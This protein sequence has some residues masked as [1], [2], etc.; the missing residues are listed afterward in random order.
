MKKTISILLCAVLLFCAFPLITSAAKKEAVMVSKDVCAVIAVSANNDAQE[1]YAA[2][3]LKTKI[4]KITGKSP[5]ITADPASVTAPAFILRKDLSLPEENYTVSE[6]DG[7]VTIIGGGQRGVLYGV[8]AFLENCCDCRY[9]SVELEYTPESENITVPAGYFCDYSPYFE[10]R[11]TDW[12]V[13][14]N[15][16]YC[17]EN[18]LN[19][20]VYAPLCTEGGG[21]IYYISSFCHTLSSEFCSPASY[22]ETHPEYYA[23]YNGE[24]TPDQLC[25]TNPDVL[26]IVTDEVLD[27]CARKHDPSQA[28]QIVSLTQSDNQHYC[29]CEKCRAL[30]DSAGSH[31]GTML[32]FVNAVAKAVKAAG[33]D[34]VAID[35]FAYQ[36]TRTPPKNIVP[37][38]NVIVRLCSI[39]CCFGHTLDD[40][41]CE[42]NTAFM[43][44]LS[45]WSRICNR[46][47]VWD[48]TTNY[49]ETYDIFPN[50]GVMQR[51]MQIFCENNVRGI[52]EEGAYYVTSCN[53]EFADLRSYLLCRLMRDPYMDYD[54][55][56]NGFLKA[57]YGPGWEYIREFLDITT[58]NAADYN[59]HLGIYQSAAD[60]LPTIT[61]KEIK[62]CDELWEKA[63]AAA[64]DEL[65]LNNLKRSELCWRYWKCSAKKG[66]FGIMQPFFKKMTLRVELKN[67]ML[68]FGGTCLG[69]GTRDRNF[70]ELDSMNLLRIPIKWST[71]YEDVIWQTIDPFVTRVY[72][73]YKNVCSLFT[74]VC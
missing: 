27:L 71:R 53:G 14:E 65:Y 32:T 64:D 66:E 52:Y 3:V 10:Y 57:Y 33:Y 28:V 31:S 5:V 1:K 44:D 11:E 45:E 59:T 26:R 16:G 35:T 74:K 49:S 56:M 36:Y 30:D 2:N 70:S 29:T 46:L 67:D 69:E 25:L 21:G 72:K 58:K 47:Y 38:D 17:E 73:L 6:K 55:E 37:D 40:P 8:Y 42:Q 4:E 41:K 60:S 23:L 61:N 20:G 15:R 51:N 22:F 63:L 62:R 68:A 12:R 39:E 18:Y 7:I 50:F 34:N 24:R 13:R 48:Y 19:G 9:Y 54:A 43:R